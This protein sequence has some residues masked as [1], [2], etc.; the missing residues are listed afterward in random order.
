MKIFKKYKQK[1]NEE[2]KE[3]TN[4]VWEKVNCRKVISDFGKLENFQTLSSNV[5]SKNRQ[6]I[7]LWLKKSSKSIINREDFSYKKVKKLLFFIL[8]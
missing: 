1:K 4:S 2:C 8:G 6:V 3:K 5:R 7:D